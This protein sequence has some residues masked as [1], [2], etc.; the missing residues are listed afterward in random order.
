MKIIIHRGTHQIGG[1]ITEKKF[2]WDNKAKCDQ[3]LGNIYQIIYNRCKTIIYYEEE[4]K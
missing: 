4:Y 3:M 2:Y 1:C